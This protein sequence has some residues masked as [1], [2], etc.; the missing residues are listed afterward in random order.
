MIDHRP[1]SRNPAAAW[2]RFRQ[3]VWGSASAGAA[4]ALFAL[5]YMRLTGTAM[6]WTGKLAVGL[7]VF[8]TVLCAGALMGLVFAS[9]RS[10]HDGEVQPHDPEG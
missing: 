3:F 2:R 1:P 8:F 4:C 7:G 10:G 9:A 6:P 5:V